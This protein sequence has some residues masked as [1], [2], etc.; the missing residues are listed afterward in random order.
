VTSEY[1]QNELHRQLLEKRT[2]ELYENSKWCYDT[3]GV[4]QPSQ[5]RFSQYTSML[6]LNWFFMCV[7]HV[8]VHHVHRQNC[9]LQILYKTYA[10]SM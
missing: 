6:I 2:E 1:D 4:I 5:V 7:H 8:S 3:P 9:P 10:N